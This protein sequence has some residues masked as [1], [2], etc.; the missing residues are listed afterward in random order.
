VR[1]CPLADAEEYGDC[2]TFGGGHYETWES[3]RRGRL[4][5]S[6]ALRHLVAGAEYEEWPRGRVVY[7]RTP[8][9]FVIYADRQAFPYREQVETA[10]NLPAGQTSIRAD[11]HYR[12]RRRIPSVPGAP[13]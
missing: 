10:F 3:W 12:S 13:A 2:L 9:L 4:P 11:S 5:L 1:G 6:P 7:E 8:K